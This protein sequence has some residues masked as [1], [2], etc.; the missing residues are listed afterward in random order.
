MGVPSALDQVPLDC[1]RT[2]APTVGDLEPGTLWTEVCQTE[3]SF[4]AARNQ[5]VTQTSDPVAI[6]RAALTTR[7]RGTAL[8]TMLLYSEQALRPL[9]SD[10]LDAT[11]GGP[12]EDI[13]N[14]REVI[15]RF[16]SGWLNDNLPGAIDAVLAR[17]ADGLDYIRLGEVLARSAPALL[18]TLVDRARAADDQE[19]RDGAEDLA[20]LIPPNRLPP[21]DDR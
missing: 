15:A 14:A 19:V 9:L 8:R 18:P 4:R 5:F 2:G 3:D 1:Q 20:G 12:H 7:H 16:D 13:H 6:F 11:T 21:Q 17:T 10:I